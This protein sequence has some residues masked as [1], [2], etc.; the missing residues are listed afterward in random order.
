M[1]SKVEEVEEDVWEDLTVTAEEAMD[2]VDATDRCSEEGIVAL[3]TGGA[4]EDPGEV[5]EVGEVVESAL[6][7]VATE[8]HSSEAARA[9]TE[10]TVGALAGMW[11]G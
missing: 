1:A 7:V 11:V 3:V 10:E 2:L 8:S 5:E 9:A 6:E 4:A